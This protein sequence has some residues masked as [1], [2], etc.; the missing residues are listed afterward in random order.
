M[1]RSY[2]LFVK[3]DQD[4]SPETRTR[5]SIF[6]SSNPGNSSVTVVRVEDLLVV[7]EVRILKFLGPLVYLRVD[8]S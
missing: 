7:F 1:Y 8:G 2:P 6:D 4:L 5:T 3:C